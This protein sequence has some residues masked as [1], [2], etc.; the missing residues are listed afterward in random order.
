VAVGRIV[1]D[2]ENYASITFS[3]KAITPIK[4][5]EYMYQQKPVKIPL[6]TIQL[7]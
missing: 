4:A 7:D 3:N 6:G 1:A 5:V 2:N